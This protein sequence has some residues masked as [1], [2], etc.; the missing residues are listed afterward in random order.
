MATGGYVGAGGAR[1]LKSC[2]VGVGG[3]HKVKEIWAGVGG[4]PKKVWSNGSLKELLMIADGAAHLKTTTDFITFTTT[5]SNL[6]E[7]RDIYYKDNYLYQLYKNVNKSYY[8]R[9]KKIGATAWE[10]EVVTGYRSY[11]HDLSYNPDEKEFCIALMYGDFFTDNTSSGFQIKFALSDGN[12]VGQSTES[13]S[14]NKSSGTRLSLIGGAHAGSIFTIAYESYNLTSYN[15]SWACYSYNGS[16][17][18]NIYYYENGEYHYPVVKPGYLRLFQGRLIYVRY[19][20]TS[21]YKIWYGNDITSI[22]NKECIFPSG[23]SVSYVGFLQ[24]IGTYLYTVFCDF[25]AKS[26][27]AAR[28]S[29]GVSFTVLGSYIVNN[30]RSSQKGLQYLGTDGEDYYFTL[31]YINTDSKSSRIILATKDF[32]TFQLV[33]AALA[34]D[35]NIWSGVSSLK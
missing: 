20:S 6:D 34:S 1:K 25:G 32:V 15:T 26:I 19:G 3:V 12:S 28:S 30:Y 17:F 22:G 2:Q 35:L 5:I 18:K 11:Y 31:L 9:K 14:L 29:D 21:D 4:V 24:I 33:V 16:Y 10:S 23:T 8:I 7:R 27:K 13:Y